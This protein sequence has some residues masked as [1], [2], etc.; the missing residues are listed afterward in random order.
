MHF[1]KFIVF[2]ITAFTCASADADIGKI[3]GVIGKVGSPVV[4]SNAPKSTATSPAAKT[5]APKEEEAD[6]E[7][8]RTPLMVIPFSQRRVNF[9]RSLDQM[10]GSNEKIVPGASY[11]V[12]SV[13]PSASPTTH[14]SEVYVE[15]LNAVVL[16]MQ[17]AGIAPERIH[18]STVTKD[19]AAD[20]EIGI[21]VGQ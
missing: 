1:C 20:Q 6:E 18:S 15:N 10:V 14:Q 13:I 2:T 8:Q 7:E 9:E 17:N 3:G 19:D 11:N 16:E 21:Y 12:I 5:A 4:A